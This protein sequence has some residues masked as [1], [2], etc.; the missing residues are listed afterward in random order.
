MCKTPT[1]RPAAAPSEPEDQIIRAALAGASLAEIAA[2]V[3]MPADRLARLHGRA[4][5]K[6]WARRTVFLRGALTTAALDGNISAL[7]R[8]TDLDARRNRFD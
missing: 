3:E 1:T 6:A 8:V 4:I 2:M 5:R 7:N